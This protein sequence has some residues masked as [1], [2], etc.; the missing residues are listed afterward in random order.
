MYRV[1]TGDMQDTL[2]EDKFV[3]GFSLIPEGKQKLQIYLDTHYRELCAEDKKKD[4]PALRGLATLLDSVLPDDAKKTLHNV[5][6]NNSDRVVLI[7]NFPELEGLENDIE[8]NSRTAYK[9]YTYF[10][11][12]AIY[13]K[14]GYESKG[15][16]LITRKSHDPD[17]AAI[18][19]GADP[20]KTDRMHRDRYGTHIIFSSPY[21]GESAHTSIIRVVKAIESVPEELQKKIHIKVG[22]NKN[23]Q[24]IVMRL[25]KMLEQL[26]TEQMD[27]G[28]LIKLF[29][30]TSDSDPEA[31]KILQKHIDR[32]ACKLPIDKGTIAIICEK[33]LFH[34]SN[35]GDPDEISKIPLDQK[36]SRIFIHN[37]SAPIGR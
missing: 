28:R 37:A 22:K 32:N 4:K 2:T 23:G 20:K 13:E 21:N 18:D 9:A 10:L 35:P 7:H 25:D 34:A 16:R 8:V 30:A 5:L 36:H 17:A 26:K 27:R 14:Y 19:R 15:T 31:I 3:N 11:G 29:I 1:Y 6:I 33:E 24:Y 12:N